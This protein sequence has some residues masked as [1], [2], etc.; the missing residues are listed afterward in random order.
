M[1]RIR[2]IIFGVGA[3]FILSVG[4]VI[5]VTEPLIW[6]RTES[7]PLGLYWRSDGP[8]TLNMWAV[9]SA[10]SEAANWAAERGYIGADWPI[11]KRVRAMEGDEVCRKDYAISINGEPVAI[12][13]EHDRSSRE[14]PVWQG[15]FRLKSHE[16]FLLND[17][18]NSLDGRYFGA[19]DM[20]D[21]RGTAALLWSRR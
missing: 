10:N 5:S 17:H 16:V 9:V 2:T 19:T 21:V 20:D 13:R 1:K 14:L 11:I 3:V 8:L 12:A 7:A 18:P 4:S 6:N 15:C